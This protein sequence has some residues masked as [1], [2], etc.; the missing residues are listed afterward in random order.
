[1]TSSGIGLAVDLQINL[2][3]NL[4][5]YLCTYIHSIPIRIH[6]FPSGPERNPNPHDLFGSATVGCNAE[7]KNQFTYDS[8]NG[9]L[10]PDPTSTTNTCSATAGAAGVYAI[11]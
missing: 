9:G 11:A 3:K 2:V 5:R 1:M 10:K 6:I 4:Y 7:S 8:A